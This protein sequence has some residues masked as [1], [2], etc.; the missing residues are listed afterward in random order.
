MNRSQRIVAVLYCLL[1]AYCCTWIPWR[2]TYVSESQSSVGSETSNPYQ[3]EKIV[4]SRSVYSAVWDA[5]SDGIRWIPA[6]A[7]DLIILRI[8]AVTAISGAA[9]FLVSIQ[10]P[11]PR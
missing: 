3:G 11:I 7:I 9:F 2:V 1:L 10:K 5:P 8:L 4:R 6:P